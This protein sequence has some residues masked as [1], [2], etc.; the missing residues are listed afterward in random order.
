MEAAIMVLLGGTVFVTAYQVATGSAVLGLSQ[1]NVVVAG[2]VENAAILVSGPGR[3][4]MEVRAP[5]HEFQFSDG[6]ARVKTGA[7][8]LQGPSSGNGKRVEIPEGQYSAATPQDIPMTP[9][10]LDENP[11]TRFSRDCT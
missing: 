5:Q 9:L 11:E 8:T 6:E 2:R 10:C 7:D 3:L 1:M 4:S